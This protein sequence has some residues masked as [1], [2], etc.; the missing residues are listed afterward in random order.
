[1]AYTSAQ[2]AAI[3]DENELEKADATA[4]VQ[5]LQMFMG[6]LGTTVGALLQAKSGVVSGLQHFSW[7][8]FVLALVMFGLIA[9]YFFKMTSLNNKQV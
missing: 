1:M 6:A 4:I 7:L 9:S 3:A 2:T 5:T 8:S